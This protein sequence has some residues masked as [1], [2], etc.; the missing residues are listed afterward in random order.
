MKIK[1]SACLAKTVSMLRLHGGLENAVEMYGKVL[2]YITG[3]TEAERRGAHFCS[4]CI[5][6]CQ[7]PVDG[8]GS[9]FL[10]LAFLFLSFFRVIF[11][12]TKVSAMKYNSYDYLLYYNILKSDIC[13]LIHIN[14][15]II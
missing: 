2:G 10:F 13:T 7:S 12:L 9:G 11:P 4:V 5:H 15:T 1:V 6:R 3:G 8:F 14:C